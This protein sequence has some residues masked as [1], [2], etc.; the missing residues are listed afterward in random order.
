LPF[1]LRWPVVTSWPNSTQGKQD[2]IE[3]SI[4]GVGCRYDDQG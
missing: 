3:E 4:Y 1:V 2:L